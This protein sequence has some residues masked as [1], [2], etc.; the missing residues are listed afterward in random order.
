METEKEPK[1]G[2]R[3]YAEE[4]A[5]L[6][7]Q[8][9]YADAIERCEKAFTLDG[10][11]DRAFMGKSMSLAQLGRPTE[12]LA[13]AEEGIRRNPSYALLYTSAAICCHRLGRD[14][15]AQRYFRQALELRPDHPQVLY[16]FAC[17][18]AE[19]ENEAEC[20]EYLTR[21]FRNLENEAFLDEAQGDPD[22]ARYV[23]SD[24]FREILAETK[25][26]RAASRAQEERP[27]ESG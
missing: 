9:R 15:D 12:G 14:E 7:A 11:L 17:Y 10:D 25:R 3:V 19:M 21:S 26:R 18:W 8:M 5:R 23:A 22:L 2:A 27:K 24:W 20:R 4:A 6:F 13:V 1:K 16:N